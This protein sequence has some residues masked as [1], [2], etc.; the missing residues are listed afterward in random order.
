M[1]SGDE[2]LPIETQQKL[3]AFLDTDLD[4]GRTIAHIALLA[5]SEGDMDRCAR[6]RKNAIKAVE[7]VRR[8]LRH[9]TA[10]RDRT[11]VANELAEL[12]TVT[13]TL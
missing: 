9:V 8:L 6:S 10:K 12:D 7:A 11:E 3:I 2:G 1:M 5:K 13:S 4:L